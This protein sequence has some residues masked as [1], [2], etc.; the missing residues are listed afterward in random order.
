MKYLKKLTT[1]RTSILIAL[2]LIAMGLGLYGY[3]H[4]HQQSVV[5][6]PPTK[7]AASS[8]SSAVPTGLTDK[9][10]AG[11]P[12]ELLIP[13]LHIDLPVIPGYYD[14]QTQKWTLSL[15]KVQYAAMTPEPNTISGNTFVYGHY[16]R[17]VFASLHNIKPDSEATVRTKNGKSYTYKLQKVTVVSPEDSGNI[18]SYQGRPILTIQTCTGLWF[19]NRQLFTFSLTKVD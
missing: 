7:V 16:R 9:T 5:V 1:V 18:F 17:S 13:S 3:A 11:M 2:L 14:S 15:D 10:G 8:D 19:Q 4:A 12:T 6:L